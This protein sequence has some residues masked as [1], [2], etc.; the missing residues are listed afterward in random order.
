[1]KASSNN[2]SDNLKQ[3]AVSSTAWGFLDKGSNVVVS[4]IIGIVLA[5]LLPPS[6]FGL[7]GLAMIV[8]GFGQ[9]FVNLGLGPALIHKQDITQRHIRVVFTTSVIASIILALV[10]Y[11]GAPL[12][13][14]ILDSNQVKP[15][16]EALS[17]IFIIAGLQIPSRAILTKRLDFKHL[18]YVSLTKSVLYGIVTITLALMGFGV[19]SLV[20]G[21]IFQRLVSLIGSYWFVRHSIKLLFAKKELSELFHFGSGMTLTGIFNYFALKGDYFIIG[22][23]LGAEM[24]GF[25][26]KAYNLMQAPTTQFVHVLSNVLFPTA[27]KIQKDNERLQAI[28]LKSMRTIAFVVLPVC[29]LIVVIAP[30][31]IVGLYGAKWQATV[32]P[33]QILGGF[34]VLRAMYNAAASFLRAKG[35]VYPLFYAQ[36]AY[37][38]AM[39]VG[40]W[41]GAKWYGLTGATIAVGLSILIMWLLQMEMNARAIKISRAKILRTLVPGLIIGITTS[42][43]T[44]FVRVILQGYVSSQLFL[45]ILLLAFCLASLIISILVIPSKYLAFLPEEFLDII[46]DYVPESKTKYIIKLKRF[47]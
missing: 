40:V 43:S 10:V 1:L 45:L 4:F 6:D 14:V 17:V 25:Y 18:F 30:E 7:I 41:L 32:L 42:L 20:I 28:F 19:W 39:V 11:L 13:S 22:R 21:N 5:R 3:K 34:G 29:L 36:I 37:G 8:V 12:A 27:S 31:L 33:L 38:L 44:A 9:I 23:L 35:W 2:Q 47:V 26:T 15:I 16:V 24:L 46:A